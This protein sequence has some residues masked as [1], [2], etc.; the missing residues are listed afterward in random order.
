MFSKY[1]DLTK[2]LGINCEKKKKNSRKVI[3]E[4]SNSPYINKDTKK[5]G[6]IN[7]N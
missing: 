1:Q 7:T 4:K 5:F 2:L 6:F 3:F